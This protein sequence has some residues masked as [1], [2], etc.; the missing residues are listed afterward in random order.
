MI[1][2]QKFQKDVYQNKLDKKFN[3]TNIEK[4]FC[5]IYG[6]L[7]ET[8]EAYRKKLPS[9]GEEI[10][11]VVI[12]LL[13]LSEILGADLESELKRKIEMNKIR[14]YKRVDGVLRRTKDW[15]SIT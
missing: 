2:L 7:S 6:E 15:F 13:G 4:E 9:V 10:A 14:E 8:Y 3:V 5:L 1:D 11:D 12:Y